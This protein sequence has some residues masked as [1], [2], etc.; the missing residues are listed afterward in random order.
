MKFNVGIIFAAVAFT[1]VFS[2]AVPDDD[3]AARCGSLGIMSLD[4][5]PEDAR[6]GNV[7]KCAGHPLGHNRPFEGTSFA[8]MDDSAETAVASTNTSNL[9]ERAC[10][11]DSEYGCT[12]KFCWKVCGNGGKWCWTASN[13]GYGPWRTCSSYHDC[14]KSF[15]CGKGCGSDCGCSC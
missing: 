11:F 8:P 14:K 9:Q 1:R 2:I 4:D 13:G 3:A 6:A 15:P 7:R 10:W 12:K 5:I